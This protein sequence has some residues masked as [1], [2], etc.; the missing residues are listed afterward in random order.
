[1]E[2][3]NASGN[4]FCHPRTLYGKCDISA[5]IVVGQP[6]F[7]QAGTAWFLRSAACLSVPRQSHP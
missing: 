4:E 7:E 3:R 6:G 1:M 5:L 2:Q